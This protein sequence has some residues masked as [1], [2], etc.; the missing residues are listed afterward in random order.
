MHK[1][2]NDKEIQ[3]FSAIMANVLAMGL[4]NGTGAGAD[5]SG[6]TGQWSSSRCQQ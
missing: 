4:R 6:L 3:P 1:D 5:S 2:Q